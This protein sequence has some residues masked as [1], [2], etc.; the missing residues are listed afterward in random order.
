MEPFRLFQL[1]V[2]RT[3]FKILLS[4]FT[5]T[6]ESLISFI[7]PYTAVNIFCHKF[8]VDLV[9]VCTSDKDVTCVYTFEL[10]SLGTGSS[11]W[12]DQQNHAFSTEKYLE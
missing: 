7:F 11:Q 1:D 8:V 4:D 6:Y 9:T 3:R 12:L 2:C 10:I 5:V